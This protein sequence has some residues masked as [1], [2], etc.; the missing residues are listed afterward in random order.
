LRRA[1]TWLAVA[2]IVGVMVALVVGA[3]WLIYG[4][5]GGGLERL[6][7]EQALSPDPV[8][9]T[10]QAGLEDP[11]SV[12]QRDLV[13]TLL[14]LYLEF[15]ATDLNTPAG[16]DRL[17]A[18]TVQPGETTGMVASRLAEE[19]LIRDAELF[20]LYMRYRRADRDLEAGDYELSPSLTIPEIAARLQRGLADE[21]VV[22]IPEGW[23]MEQIAAMLEQESVLSGQEFLGL[24]REA[25]VDRPF[26]R[27]RPPGAALEGYLFPDT[28]RLPAEAKGPDL[29]ERMLENF[30]RRVTPQM[31]QDAA[32]QDLSLFQVVTLASIVEREG[33]VREE[34]P[35]IAGVYRNRFDQDMKLDADPTV[36]YA[37][38]FQPSTGQWWKRPM[39][40]EEY[41]QV[42]SPYNTYLYRGLPPGPIC[43]PGLAAIEAVIYPIE[44]DYLFFVRNDVVDDGSHVFARTLDEHQRNR[45]QYQR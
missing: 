40:L 1:L 28:Y 43:N 44:S 8:R 5:V 9:P 15:K 34:L 41:A 29:V 14:E 7:Q 11:P 30:D 32:A 37:V 4:R 2:L 16:D 36:Q 18:F 3:G 6:K 23:R 17:I 35:L 13:H 12:Q 33:V 24:A 19:G 39:R 42:D 22:T 21:V 26:L 25:D 27:D 20:R 38:G 45:E 31:R 10:A